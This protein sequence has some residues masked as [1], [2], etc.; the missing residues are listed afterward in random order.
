MIALPLGHF[1]VDTPGGALWLIAPAVGI[2]WDLSPAEIGFLITA[3]NLG[4]G[5]GY[6][7]AGMMADRFSR[8]GLMMT[9]TVWWVVI[10]YLVASM[11][12]GYWT[13]A[14]LLAA[15]AAGDAAWH[16]MATG[17][18][19]QH[20]PR[21]RALALGVHLTGGIM[22]EVV[23]PLAVG[24]LLGYFDWRVVFRLALIPAVLMGLALLYFHR[25]ILPPVGP[26]M[27]RADLGEI[28]QVWRS[29]AG[30]AM[31]GLGVTYSMSFVGMMAMMPVL[32]QN[33]HGYSPAWTGAAF[34][35]MLFGGGVAAPLMGQLSDRWGRK[36]VVVVSAFVGAAGILLTAFSTHPA[37]LVLGVVIAGTVLTGM[38]PVYL[39]GAV[40]M[41]GKRESTALGLIYGVMDGLGALGGLLAGWAGTN[42]LRYALV[43]AAGAAAL[44]G[45]F[46]WLHPFE[47][48]G[49]A[50]HLAPEET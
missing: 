43:F 17:T 26:R 8:R 47:V 1:S 39:A 4:A 12:P 21:R 28:L 49:D 38:R 20:M 31:F 44:S 23:A 15:A 6:I 2:A 33:Y 19:V 7:P 42:D 9:T 11:A 45:V 24:I 16:P 46:G 41:V 35:A 50:L 10:G 30:L 32:F 48:H 14:L 40:E 25:Y 22:A 13:L 5:V 29:P 3:H 36:Q 34:A 27:T 18:M 37:L